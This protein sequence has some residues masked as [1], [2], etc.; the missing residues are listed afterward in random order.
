MHQGLDPKV[1][2]DGVTISWVHAP[3]EKFENQVS[4][5]FPRLAKNASL[6]I[7]TYSTYLQYR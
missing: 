4:Q 6:Y 5:I 2:T 3:P 1:N 7:Y